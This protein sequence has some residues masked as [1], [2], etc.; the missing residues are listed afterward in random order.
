MLVSPDHPTFLRTKTH[1]HGYVPFALCGTGIAADKA[2]TYD[3]VAAGQLTI[4]LPGH[5]VMPLFLGERPV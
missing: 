4:V 2:R 5:Q 3:E 1:S